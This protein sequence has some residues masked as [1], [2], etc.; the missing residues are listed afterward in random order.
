MNATP[1]SDLEVLQELLADDLIFTNHL[2]Q[3]L[4]KEDDRAARP[5]RPAESH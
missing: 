2:G 5:V 3:L 1:R 4:H